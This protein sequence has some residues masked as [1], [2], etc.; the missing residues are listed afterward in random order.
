MVAE[1]GQNSREPVSVLYLTAGAVR[2]FQLVRTNWESGEDCT[3]LVG[4]FLLLWT[5][6]FS[7]G[8]RCD[9]HNHHSLLRRRCCMSGVCCEHARKPLKF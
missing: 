3:L 2:I 1:V 9:G 8:V 6:G 5:R 7:F 4:L